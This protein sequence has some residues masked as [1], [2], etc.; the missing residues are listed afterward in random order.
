MADTQADEIKRL[1]RTIRVK[2]KT[3]EYLKKKIK[4]LKNEVSDLK[5]QLSDFQNNTVNISKKK[6][7]SIATWTVRKDSDGY[8]RA[9]KFID[10]KTRCVYIGKRITKAIKPKLI[11]REKEIRERL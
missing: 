8:F 4:N 2:T 6:S 10:G 1:N 11:K 9:R 5:N 3:N 7:Q